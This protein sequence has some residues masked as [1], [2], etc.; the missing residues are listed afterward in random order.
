MPLMLP[1]W[2]GRQAEHR[3]RSAQAEEEEPLAARCGRAQRSR[4]LGGESCLA[5]EG[6]NGRC[7]AYDP[8]NQ[9]RTDVGPGSAYAYTIQALEFGRCGSCLSQAFV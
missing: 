8:F 7:S 4:L 5:F 1:S 3:R 6:A 2:P 9:R